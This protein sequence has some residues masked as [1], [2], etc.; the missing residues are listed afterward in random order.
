MFKVEVG[1]FLGV[2]GGSVDFS[3]SCGWIIVKRIRKEL[4][5]L[6]Q[7]NGRFFKGFGIDEINLVVV[8]KIV[9][10]GIRVKFRCL[11]WVIL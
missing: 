9:W 11:V 2:R 10:E 8:W 7:G 5:D 4:K 6:F 1:I 3:F